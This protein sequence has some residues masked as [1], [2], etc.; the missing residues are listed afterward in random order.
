MKKIWKVLLGVGFV[1]GFAGIGL[2]IN[3]CRAKN[4]KQNQLISKA[5]NLNPG[6]ILRYGQ[7]KYKIHTFDNFYRNLEIKKLTNITF[8]TDN[9]PSIYAKDDWLIK[10]AEKWNFIKSSEPWKYEVSYHGVGNGST[11]YMWYYTFAKNSE[12]EK[13][14]NQFDDE[15]KRQINAQFLDWKKQLKAVDIEISDW[16]INY[17]DIDKWLQNLRNSLIETQKVYPTIDSEKDIVSFSNTPNLFFNFK[18]KVLEESEYREAAS[19]R[20]FPTRRKYYFKLDSITVKNVEFDFRVGNQKNN[21]FEAAYNEFKKQLVNKLANKDFIE[22]DSDWNL[23]YI[24]SEVYGIKTD[25]PKYALFKTNKWYFDQWIKKN[26]DPIKIKH[27]NGNEF[28]LIVDIEKSNQQGYINFLVQNNKTGHRMPLISNLKVNYKKTDKL[29]K[30]DIINKLFT[31]NNGKILNF[32]SINNENPTAIE[33]DKEILINEPNNKI[34]LTGKNY[35]CGLWKIKTNADFTFTAPNDNYV[36]KINGHKVDLVNNSF[37]FSLKDNREHEADNEKIPFDEKDKSKLQNELNETNSHKKNEYIIVI[38]EYDNINLSSTPK[39]IYTKK[40]II[41]NKSCFMDFKWYAWDPKRNFLQRELIEEYIIDPKTGKLKLD[42]NNNPIK[43]PKYDHLIDPSTGTKKQYIWV[44]NNSFNKLS[45]DI[46]SSDSKKI[47][48][49]K[50]TNMP[51]GSYTY[52]TSKK[53]KGF[54]AEAIVVNKAALKI[55]KKQVEEFYLIKIPNANIDGWP[56]PIKLDNKVSNDS[57]IST[58][59]LYLFFSRQKEDVNSFKFVLIKNDEKQ[60][61]SN[62]LFIDALKENTNF[63]GFVD[64]QI[65]SSFW[66]HNEGKK[67]KWYLINQENISDETINKFKYEELWEYWKKYVSWYLN[68]NQKNIDITPI[69]NFNDLNGKY[70]TKDKLI[71]ALKTFNLIE[72]FGNFNY[73]KYVFADIDIENIKLLSN[74]SQVIVPINFHLNTINSF[75]RLTTMQQEYIINLKS[76]NSEDLIKNIHINWN[77]DLIN[78]EIETT[79]NKTKLHNWLNLNKNRLILNDEIEKNLIDFNWYFEQIDNNNQWLII[80]ALLKNKENDSKY[81]LTND[82]LK[83][84]TNFD[85]NKVNKLE[86]F[87][88]QLINLNGLTNNDLIKKH[89]IVEIIEQIKNEIRQYG[90]L[91]FSENDFEILD[92]ES[93]YEDLAKIYATRQEAIE[94]RTFLK[95]KITNKNISEDIFNFEIINVAQINIDQIIDLSNLKLNKFDI[96]KEINYST[97]E[98]Y[99]KLLN[100]IERE[101]LLNLQ[102]QL[103]AF[104]EKLI[105]NITI[106]YDEQQFKNMLSNLLNHNVLSKLV[107]KPKHSMIKNKAEF[108]AIN[109]AKQAKSFNFENLVLNDLNIEKRSLE[110]I[111]KTIIEFIDHQLKDI[112]NIHNWTLGKEYFINDIDNAERLMKLVETPGINKLVMFIKSPFNKTKKNFTVKNYLKFALTKEEKDK[113][114]EKQKKTLSK[115]SK[116]IIIFSVILALLVILIPTIIL[117]YRKKSKKIR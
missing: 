61:I 101:V 8:N 102:N 48:Y 82:L 23:P 60:E 4:A 79:P 66:D 37:K 64:K 44:D 13:N 106:E 88:P 52:F 47:L 29:A 58:E 108:F 74:K 31:H 33:D 114:Q 2:V 86:K 90:N 36:V 10:K 46:N 22:L 96:N 100:S 67:F 65:F 87:I 5:N 81:L 116:L 28:S 117:I 107:L 19:G 112:N 89:L 94:N 39:V 72:K 55:L 32:D 78:D 68:T 26:I 14:I 53:S 6:E 85:L 98:E 16:K 63:R 1:L 109:T 34:G 93:K 43:N 111:Q 97:K 113:W 76:N 40:Y 50:T 115:N 9:I 54:L 105:L 15:I 24:N 12:K 27:F 51:F 91:T 30:L 84:K 75:Y 3:H 25:D 62:K 104:N 83:L 69:L 41:E 110:D 11:A 17:Q 71:E 49:A 80:N 21:G 70:E 59:G 7:K 56:K 42:N 99:E 35:Y 20:T 103:N 77:I 73:K 45:S 95:V 18:S 92:L 38:E 57:Y